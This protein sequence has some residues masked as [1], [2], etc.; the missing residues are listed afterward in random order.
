MYDSDNNGTLDTVQPYC[1]TLSMA[2]A[3]TFGCYTSSESGYPAHHPAPSTLS[4]GMRL[5]HPAATLKR[6]VFAN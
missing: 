1:A 3:I 6:H 2:D 4:H 5:P